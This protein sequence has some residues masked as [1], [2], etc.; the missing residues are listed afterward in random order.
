MIDDIE[1]SDTI[2]DV[3]IGLGGVILPPKN[4]LVA[5]I[6]ADTVAFTACLNVEEETEEFNEETQEFDTVFAS[7]LEAAIEKAEEKLQKIL[8]RT[9]CLTCELHFTAGRENFR[10]AIFPEYK[11]NRTGRAPLFL[12]EVK[13][14]LL[15]RYPGSIAKGWEADDI[16]VYLKNKEPDK[17]MM[18]AV[19]K[20]VLHCLPGTH[21]N[22]YESS[23]YNI[24]MKFITVT[25]EEA[26]IWPYL[27][28]I[29]GDKT[30][31]IP[32]CKGIGKARAKKFV[33][34]G[35]SHD[36]LWEG[37]VSAWNSKGMTEEDAQLT[38]QLVNMHCLVEEEGK[39]MIKLWEPKDG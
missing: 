22:Y 16:V 23:L 37:V 18:V 29:Y 36:E 38:M 24:D 11:A 33:R 39:Y 32:G 19:D 28:C 15:E 9:G 7:D 6:D 27:Q 10:Y 34:E 25:E 5:L 21:F 1:G 26:K 35:M 2:T 3:D 12:K 14:A 31:N 17:Y 8:E 4:D 13:E 30:D 20:D